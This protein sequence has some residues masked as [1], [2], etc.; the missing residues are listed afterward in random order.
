MQGNGRQSKEVDSGQLSR[1]TP[2]MR[3]YLAIKAQYPDMLLFYRMGDFYEMFHGDAE[4]AARLL[5]ITLTRRGESGGEAIKMAGVPYHAADQYL[6]RLVKLGESVAIC[7]QI[8]DPATSKGPVERK[9]TRVVTPGTLTDAALLEEKRDNVLLAVHRD[10]ATLGLAWLS[11]ASGRLAV[12]ETALANAGTELERIAPAEILIAEE[13]NADFLNG[14]TAALKRLPPWQFELDAAKRA[15]TQQFQTHDLSGFGA[16]EL[17][18]SLCA[19]GALLEYARGTQGTAIG[20][21]K[22]LTVEHEGAYV[23][24]DP[25]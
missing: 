16:G 17:G 24:V 6:A 13:A 19:A 3:Q 10:R 23:R 25:A 4:R 1:H 5:N 12:M 18:A 22:A 8:G 9:V 21:V 20:Q 7:E 2:M 11:L 14:S 15:L